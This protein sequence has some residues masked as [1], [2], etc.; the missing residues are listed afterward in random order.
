M[1][2]SFKIDYH[3]LILG[4][5]S[6]ILHGNKIAFKR[7]QMVNLNKMYNSCM[8]DYYDSSIQYKKTLQPQGE[9]TK[10]FFKVKRDWCDSVRK[11]GYY[12]EIEASSEFLVTRGRHT[13]RKLG[14]SRVC[15]S[16]IFQP[17]D[18]RGLH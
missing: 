2:N 11:T 10:K 1:Q 18:I 6:L 17:S 7:F 4:L 8:Y 15:S 12:I 13:F 14:F 3:N 9:L 5:N 16:S